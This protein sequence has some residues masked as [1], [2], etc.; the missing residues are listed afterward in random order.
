MISRQKKSSDA[1]P[2]SQKQSTSVDHTSVPSKVK[3]ASP[4]FMDADDD[5]G[6]ITIN[7]ER[8]SPSPMDKRNTE[9]Q[10]LLN[11]KD[12]KDESAED[13]RESAV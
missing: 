9:M 8:A 1:K 5:Y 10:P 11:A 2:P 6:A 4:D 7:I 13:K 3:Q 12:G